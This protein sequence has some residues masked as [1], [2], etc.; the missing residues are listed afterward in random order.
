[1]RQLIWAHRL[2]LQSVLMGRQLVTLHPV[3]KEKVTTG[4]QLAFF[5][6]VWD[7]SP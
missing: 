1:M 2:R 7:P 6:S 5:D 4:A 3:M